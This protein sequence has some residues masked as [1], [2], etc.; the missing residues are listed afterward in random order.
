MSEYLSDL[1]QAPPGRQ[2]AGRGRMAEPVRACSVHAGPLTGVPHDRG[3]TTRGQGPMRCS[4]PDEHRHAQARWPAPGQPGDNRLADIDGQ[5][6]PVA[7]STFASH[8]QIT[9]SPVDVAQ[10]QSGDFPGPQPQA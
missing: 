4:H 6:Q 3:H 1:I 5:R 10:L 9:G 8:E 7:A 2:H